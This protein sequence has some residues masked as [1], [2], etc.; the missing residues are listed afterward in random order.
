MQQKFSLRYLLVLLSSCGMMAASVGLLINSFGVFI[1]PI[2]DDLML[3]QGAVSMM[4]TVSNLCMA[5][6]GMLTN[7]LLQKLR[8]KPILIAATVLLVGTTVGLGL[9]SNLFVLYLFCA[10]RGFVG[11]IVGN[12]L[13]AILVNNWFVK[14]NGTFV[15]IAMSMSG[16]I[17]AVF[18]PVLSSI[19]QASGWRVGFF[20]MAGFILLF[21]LPGILSP[22][23]VYPSL[24]GCL[25]YGE[26]PQTIHPTADEQATGGTLA[27]V[28]LLPFLLISL[29]QLIVAFSTSFPQ[30]FPGFA[31]EMG[32]PA[33]TG[34]L[35]V[36]VN[37]AMNTGGKL[38][39]GLLSDRIG[40]KK[41]VFIFSALL[42][43]GPILL[44]IFRP[45]CLLPAAILTGVSYSLSTVGVVLLVRSAFG[46]EKYNQVYPK[47]VLLGTASNALGFSLIGFLFDLTGSYMVSFLLLQALLVVEFASFILLFRYIEKR[48]KIAE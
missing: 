32:L 19:I 36:S 6:S 16:V 11:G 31:R 17:G 20:A 46:V 4:H 45:W 26:T 2:A 40:A 27:K 5:V 12:V 43:F 8:L 29:F 22:I 30:F 33:A 15:S 14:N 37:L 23:D 39:F 21:E 48:R 28:A 44:I 7:K 1:I 9:S 41:T 18:S 24:V 35:M 34:A 25:A 13:V 10:V 47:M 38:S 3:G 42:F